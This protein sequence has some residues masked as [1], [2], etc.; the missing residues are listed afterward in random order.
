MDDDPKKD[1]KQDRRP[2]G[3]G[4]IISHCS[5]YSDHSGLSLCSPQQE[6]VCPTVHSSCLLLYL[7]TSPVCLSVHLCPCSGEGG[8]SGCSLLGW[9]WE[10]CLG[11]QAFSE[12]MQ[13]RPL[14]PGL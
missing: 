12:P 8:M 10:Q 1:T 13:T 7:P 2:W 14:T 9:A 3:Y 11:Q 5:L 4:S 6:S